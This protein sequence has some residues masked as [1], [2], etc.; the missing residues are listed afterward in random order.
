LWK[1]E[2]NYFF[3]PQEVA[4]LRKASRLIDGIAAAHKSGDLEQIGILLKKEGVV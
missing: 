2:R 3:G 1:L 4:T